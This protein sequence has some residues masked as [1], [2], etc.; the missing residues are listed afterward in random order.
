MLYGKLNESIHKEKKDDK[1]IINSL[2]GYFCAVTL[3]QHKARLIIPHIFN[4]IKSPACKLVRP[5][6]TEDQ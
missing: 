6:R 3:A 2:K 1:S 5:F 4:L